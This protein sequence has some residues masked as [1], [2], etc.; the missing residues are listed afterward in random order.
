MGV[1]DGNQKATALLTINV[2]GFST[3]S[4][5]AGAATVLYSTPFAATGGTPPYV[6]A[7]NGL[8]TGLTMS[9]SGTLSGTV[10]TPGTLTFNVQVSDSQGLSAT[11][12][13]TLNIRT[14]P[15]SVQTPTLPNG[16]VGTPYSQ[17]LTASG[18]NPPYTW[19]TTSGA[20]PSG[21]SLSASGTISGN[22]TAPG[23]LSF[24]VQATDSNGGVASALASIVVLPMPMT[25][26][27]TSLPSGAVGFAYPQ[28]ILGATGGIPPYSFSITGGGLPGGMSL[29]NGV[30]SGTPGTSGSFPLTITATDSAGITATASPGLTIRPNTTDLLLLTGNLSFALQSGATS[31]PSSQSV[32]LQ[33][34]TAGQTVTYTLAV[35]PASPWLSVTAGSQT[36]DNIG[37]ALTGQ[38]LTLGTGTYTA[39][40]VLTCTSASCNG[41]TQSIGVVLTVTAAPPQLGVTSTLLSFSATAAATGTQ[42]QPLGIENTG[43]GSLT[44][45][46]VSCEASWCIVTS[47]P[48]AIAAGSTDQVIVAVDPTQLSP[49]LSRTAVDVSSA[50]GAVSVPVDV[51]ISQSASMSL[52]PAGAQFSAQQGG[53]PGNPNGSFLISASGGTA[54]WTAA[55]VTGATWITLNTP[56][57]TASG[58]Q[59]G[60]VSY[61]INSSA[62]SLTPQAYYATI[63]VTS[64]GVVNSPQDYQV[65]LNVVAQTTSIQPD[66]EP[67]GLLFIAAGS[68]PAGQLVQVYS[69]SATP[70]SYQASASANGGGSWLSVDTSV[71]TTSSAAPGQSTVTV[72]TAGL[73]PGVYTGGVSYSSTGASI[74]TVSVTLVVATGGSGSFVRT[75]ISAAGPGASGQIGPQ[76]GGCA[77]ASLIAAPTGLAANFSA[78]T[79]WPTPLSIYL[80]NN[81]GAFV[82]DGQVTATFTNG[83]PPLS[84]SLVNAATGLYSATWTPRNAAS[85][86]TIQ[87][88]ATNAGGLAPATAQIAG[89]VL[90]NQAPVVNPLATVNPFNP[91]VGGALAPGTIIAIYG[92]NLATQTGQPTTIPL[93]TNFNGTSVIIGGRPAPLYYVSSGQINAQ[94]PFELDPTKQYQVVVSANGAIATPQTI[95]MTSAVPGLA[96][97]TNGTLIAQHAD[98]SLVLP[99]SP[100]QPGEYIVMYLLGMGPTNNPVA[101]GTASPSSPLAIPLVAPVVTLGGSQIPVAFAGLTPSLVG[102]YQ[103]NIQLPQ[104]IAGG[105]QVLTVAQGGNV[106]NTTIVPVQQQ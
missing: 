23:T 45:N 77:P 62:A 57:G 72:N 64:S 66:P 42:S 27:T 8:P 89:S 16:T 49:G 106:S 99:T 74:R 95:Q 98:G 25:V 5:P 12:G 96:A 85:Q 28:Q 39:S 94:V 58:T 50:A 79:S 68:A 47:A 84:L 101:S 3:S 41:N 20:L 76:A 35:A 59:P 80:V 7:A 30:I 73:A 22:P 11:S 44:V 67:G 19:A 17:V 103:I 69:N 34:T 91:Q 71:S 65:I 53:A 38:A 97:F 13:F 82:T 51:F 105:N 78:P 102:L 88:R 4:I 1:T 9:G 104:N 6:F 60:T 93:A 46:S 21:L 2:L 90:P 31:V 87:A 54:N 40:I 26:T 32:G 15:V 56:S 14:A 18:G 48:S 55:E 86:V 100:A 10:A 36:P 81:C 63:R 52:S 92:A 43:G 70:V 75:T 83:D 29:A 33:S 24:S 61:S 37:V